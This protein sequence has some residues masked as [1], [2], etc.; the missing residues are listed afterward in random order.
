MTSSLDQEVL[1]YLTRYLVGDLTIADFH[2][3]FMHRMWELPQADPDSHRLSRQVALR[4]A[5]YTSDYCTEAELRDASW[6]CFPSQSRCP[7][8]E[9]ALTIGVDRGGSLGRACEQRVIQFPNEGL[10]G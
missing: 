3:W 2:R 4:L 5:E 7:P 9:A 6:S 10:I 8:Q 1:E